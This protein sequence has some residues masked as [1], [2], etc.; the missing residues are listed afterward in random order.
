VCDGPEEELS[1][2]QVVREVL[3]DRDPFDVTVYRLCH[4][5]KTGRCARPAGAPMNDCRYCYL[6]SDDDK[7]SADE[8][9][10]SMNWWH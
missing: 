4:G 7:R 10:A 3:R 1:L 6:L 5:Q 2:I 9:V 8:V